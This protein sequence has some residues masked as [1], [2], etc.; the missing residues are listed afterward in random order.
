MIPAPSTTVAKAYKQ[1]LYITDD[2]DAVVDV[3]VVVDL[4]DAVNVDDDDLDE[5][6]PA[7]A[8]PPLRASAK[9]GNSEERFA[10]P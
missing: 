9:R 4:V 6:P 1:R 8:V 2:D 10:N 5:T 3:D 7:N